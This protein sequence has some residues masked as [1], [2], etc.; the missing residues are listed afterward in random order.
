MTVHA[1]LAIVILEGKSMGRGRV[2]GE[3]DRKIQSLWNCI[4]IIK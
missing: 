2:F 3:N 1:G 4:I